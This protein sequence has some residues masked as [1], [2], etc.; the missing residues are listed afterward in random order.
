MKIYFKKNIKKRLSGYIE[1][2]LTNVTLYLGEDFIADFHSSIDLGYGDYHVDAILDYADGTQD[3]L[4][5]QL[6]SVEK[7]DVKLTFKEVSHWTT[8]QALLLYP[9]FII[10]VLLMPLF[11]I[12]YFIYM[13]TVDDA[14][15][16][17]LYNR[18]G[19]S[20]LKLM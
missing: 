8:L 17:K 10:G 15:C 3:K 9:G 6:I 18:K 20:I 2:D 12:G 7:W 11:G 13:A 16:K 14:Y 1:K 4:E 19:I 5:N